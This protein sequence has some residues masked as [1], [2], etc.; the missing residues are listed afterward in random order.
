MKAN[1]IV[2]AIAMGLA[3]MTGT[4]I[5]EA[6]QPYDHRFVVSCRTES[7]KPILDCR[8]IIYT[9]WQE[10][11]EIGDIIAYRVWNDPNRYSWVA[12][13]VMNTDGRNYITKGINNDY[14]D[15]P[16]YKGRIIGKV[17]RVDKRD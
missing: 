16:V 7:M 6:A 17:V 3:M 8:D 11:Y 9:K 13:K 1:E 10:R 4:G 2:A 14:F 12:H 5:A 15:E